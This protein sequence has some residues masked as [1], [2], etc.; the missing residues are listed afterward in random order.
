MR[1]E[2]Q[3]NPMF[4]KETNDNLKIYHGIYED[5]SEILGAEK[6]LEPFTGK[7]SGSP[8]DETMVKYNEYLKGYLNETDRGILRTL[9][10]VGK[11]YKNHP[12]VSETMETLANE[13]RR[14]SKTGR[15]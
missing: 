10:V 13:L 3:Y 11:P 12:I 9:L 4:S 1:K 14:T 7:R 15:I 6:H 5:C 8:S 2:Y